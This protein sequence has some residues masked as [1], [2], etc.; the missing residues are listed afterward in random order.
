MDCYIF[1]SKYIDIYFDS[2]CDGSVV[3]CT[4]AHKNFLSVLKG[5]FSPAT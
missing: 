5:R 1:L 2:G 3:Q 4:V